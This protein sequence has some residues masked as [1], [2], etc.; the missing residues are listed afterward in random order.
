MNVLLDVNILGKGF[1]AEATRTGIFRATESFVRAM[2]RRRD[3]SLSF[4]AEAS[5]VS[6][7]QLLGYDRERGGV[8]GDRIRRAWRQPDVTDAEGAALIARILAGE[9]EGRDVQRDRASLMLLNATARR[10]PLPG[11]SDVVHS[12]RT[13]LPARSRISARVRALTVHDV[14]PLMH[15]EWMYQG[16]EAQVRAI[17]ASMDI[18]RDFVIE[19]SEATAGDV[20][21]LLGMPRE[22]MFVTP[23]AADAEVFHARE[24]ADRIEQVR[25]RLG[26]PRGEYVLSLCTLEPRKNLPHLIRSFF[27][28]V[29]Q[30]KLPD[31]H[32][33]LVGPTGWNAD[34]VFA[35]LEQRPDLRARVRLTGFVPDSDL[36]ALY[37]GAHA[38]VYPS[39][40]EGFGL[41]VLEAMQCGTPVVT[42]NTSSLPEVVGDAALTVSPTDG[43]ALCDAL[44]RL[45][46][47]EAL[48]A[49][50]RRR[51]LERARLFSWDR[52]ADLT[53][54]AY[55]QMLKLSR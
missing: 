9:D 6:E 46:S 18:E 22:R 14:I 21:E 48:A 7:L 35:T 32:L 54:Q 55:R 47:D 27:R 13:A 33:V 20:A 41:P 15:P 40:Y 51:G 36:A 11:V 43:D 34:E 5:W 44:R 10:S 39:L 31:L 2:L 23:F 52:T 19:N 37:A 4:A 49:E 1:G 3:I 8:L 17:M 50:L 16:A 26:I 28:L 45:L 42:S 53:V 12:M 30:E 25:G 29:D 24:P 38:F